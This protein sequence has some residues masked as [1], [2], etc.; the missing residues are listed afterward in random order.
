MCPPCTVR[1]ITKPVALPRRIL[2]FAPY[3]GGG[4]GGGGGGVVVW[5]GDAVRVRARTNCR[6][7]P[8]FASFVRAGATVCLQCTCVGVWFTEANP[9]FCPVT[10]AGS[11]G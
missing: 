9:F 3:P 11:R 5:C 2:S 7:C 8:R 4:G 1:G 6:E 10:T